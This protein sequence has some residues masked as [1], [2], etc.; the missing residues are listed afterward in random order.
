MERE[1]KRNREEIKVNW[2]GNQRG[3]EK[4]SKT[5]GENITEEYKENEIE[6]ER[7]SKRNLKGIKDN[8]RGNHRGVERE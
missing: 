1:W 4:E 8:W 6:I 3:M 5:T 7:E 2:S